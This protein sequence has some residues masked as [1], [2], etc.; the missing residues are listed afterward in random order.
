MSHAHRIIHGW[1]MRRS[2]VRAAVQLRTTLAEPIMPSIRS[3]V[4]GPTRAAGNRLFQGEKPK[5]TG[6]ST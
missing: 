3:W 2:E 6:I 1:Y 4:A 5:T